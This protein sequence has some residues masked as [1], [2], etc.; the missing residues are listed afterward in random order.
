MDFGEVLGKAWRIIWK[1]KILWI[2]GIFAGCSS[3]GGGGGG[4]GGSGWQQSAGDGQP[5]GPGAAS[6]I[7][8]FF[9]QAGQWI[10]D[11]LWVVALAG[12]VVLIL[13]VLSI[14]LGTIGKIGLIRGTAQADGGAEK[15]QFSELF[16]GSMPFFWRV[17]LLSFLIGL[18]V[19]IIFLPLALIGVVTA[20]VGFLCALPLICILV[21]VLAVVG[22][23][24]QQAD[25]AMVIENLGIQDGVRRGWG[26]V[27][28]S[29]GPVLVIWLITTV[30]GFIIGLV[31]ALPLLIAVVPVVIAFATSQGEFP[32]AGVT[33]AALCFAL[34]LPV[35]LVAQ[36]ILTA[37]I[38]SVWALTFLRLTRAPES[39]GT[40]EALPANA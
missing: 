18:A 34:Y 33:V 25:A 38:Q 28:K 29:I 4:G 9:E 31:L 24:V 22:L 1:H 35:L 10:G 7:E 5:F 26:V 16:R 36:G 6:D 11:H 37:Y 19:L 15:L 20:G 23:V 32:T 17:F 40:K 12:L 39:T 2:F 13:M 21:P 30:I 27:K 8:R 14:F 3:G